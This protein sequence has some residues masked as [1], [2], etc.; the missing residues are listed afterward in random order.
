MNNLI[1]I[2]EI[3][4]TDFK[5]AVKFYRTVLDISIE[6]IEIEGYQMGI[7]A[8]Q[9]DTLN[10]ILVKGIDYKSTTEGT[11]VYFN[12]GND[13]QPMLDLVEQN[14]GKLLVPKTEISPEMGCFA[15]FIDTEGNKVGLHSMP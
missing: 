2:V 12:A 9:Q 3:A 15:I 4:V 14:G 8:N 6:E 10:V 7:M 1:S 13:L 11:L 5:R